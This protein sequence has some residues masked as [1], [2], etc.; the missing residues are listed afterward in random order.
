MATF[1]YKSPT[2][3]GVVVH[4]DAESQEAADDKVTAFALRWATMDSDVKAEV[5]TSKRYL[6]FSGDGFPVGGWRH[7]ID[8]FSEIMEAM[9]CADH[10]LEKY[11]DWY[12]VVDLQSKK[13]VADYR[14]K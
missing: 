6:V 14:G 9:E 4:V 10:R 5:D 8:S 3:P 1:T 7:F 11:N 13:L 2:V 12:Q